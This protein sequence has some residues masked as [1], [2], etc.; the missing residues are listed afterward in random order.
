MFGRGKL[1]VCALAAGCA[2]AMLS[3]V[4]AQG[5]VVTF[6]PSPA[7]VIATNSN[8]QEINNTGTY[9]FAWNAGGGPTVTV[10]GVQFLNSPTASTPSGITI[11]HNSP[12]AQTGFNSVHPYGPDMGTLIDSA[13]FSQGGG[14]FDLTLNGLTVGVPYRAQFISGQPSS[15]GQRLMQ[16]TSGSS[17]SG[18]YQVAGSL[19]EGGGNSRF[20]YANFTADSP[21][22]AFTFVGDP[23]TGSRAFL[24]GVSVFTPAA[25]PE[26]ASLGILS[27]GA[28]LA[29]RRRRRA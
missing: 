18:F 25:V 19:D 6:S 28:L 9:R 7:G 12:N 11:T 10:N 17:S 8:G 29:L 5:A 16:I 21:T 20:M 4:E 3:G 13:I 24:N 26:P 15:S 27:G 2:V 22:Q 14:T 23:A 1:S